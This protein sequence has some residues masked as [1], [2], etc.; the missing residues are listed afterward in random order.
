MNNHWT[1]E[2]LDTL[3]AV[4]ASGQHPSRAVPL[5]RRRSRDSCASKA[6]D[7]GWRP[8]PRTKAQVNRRSDE[9]EDR[10]SCSYIRQCSM[11]FAMDGIAVLRR[12]V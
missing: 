2:E 1:P 12:R 4:L 9:A 5:L 11:V 10:S 7:L 8:G 3:R 6:T